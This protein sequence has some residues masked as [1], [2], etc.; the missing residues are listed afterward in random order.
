MIISN[1]RHI[2]DAS[3]TGEVT[4]GENTCYWTGLPFIEGHKA[5]A[6]SVRILMKRF[7]ESGNVPFS[8]LRGAFSIF[9]VT[10]NRILAFGDNSDLRTVYVNERAISD[11]F[12]P[13]IGH[14][15]SAEVRLGF[16][17]ESIAQTYSVGRILNGRTIVRAVTLLD[18]QEYVE[19]VQGKI[20]VARKDV[21]DIDTAADG[22]TPS[23]FF[24]SVATALGGAEVSC[25]LTGGYDSRLV[26]GAL[27]SRMRVLPTLSGDVEGNAD[28]AIGSTV[29]K[30]AGV[31]LRLV[32]TPQPMLSD[33]VLQHLFEEN[34]GAAGFST[35]SAFRLAQYYRGIQELG[36]EIHVTGDGGV[37][38]KD[39]EWIQDFPFYKRKRTNLPRFYRQRLA[40]NRDTRGAGWAL[41]PQIDAFPMATISRLSRYVRSTNS[42]TYDMLYYHVNGRRTVYYNANNQGVHLYAPLLERDFVAYSYALPR[43]KRFFNNSI[44]EMLSS[45][46][47]AIAKLPTVY[48]TTAATGARYVIRDV[49]YQLIDYARR[50]IRMISRKLIGRT[51]MLESV[52]S[53]DAGVQLRA[54]DTSAQAVAYAKSI[55]VI[56][57]KESV[58]TLSR[59][60]LDA[61]LQVFLVSRAG[62]VEMS[63]NAD[64]P[65]S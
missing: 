44:R 6:D 61:V 31:D 58:N 33:G 47:P 59:Q 9:L 30:A 11:R 64:I 10:P 53:W 45:E 55:G 8:M 32:R 21:D 42:Q 2:R 36:A 13:L 56:A 29:A 43:Y 65:D 54:L 57:D 37:L 7:E 38:H 50:A 28:V 23:K 1:E 60:H 25:A 4:V 62:G 15:H 41:R 46:Y 14:L 49:G 51:P 40:F 24:N 63:A 34:D 27:G 39:W 16:D 35:D 20:S 48:G 18:K 3:G 17:W 12:L 52:I 19:I 26:F 5:G 22:F